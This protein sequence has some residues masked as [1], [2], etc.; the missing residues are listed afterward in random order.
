MQ[1]IA[2]LAER[3]EMT[4]EDA[5]E[6]LRKLQ[7]QVNDPDTEIDDDA[8]DLLLDIDEDETVFEKK[9]AAIKKAE[10]KAREEERKK[11][12]AEAKRKA[13]EAKRKAAAKKKAVPAKKKAATSTKSHTQG[14]ESAQVASEEA[15]EDEESESAEGADV[16]EILSEPEEEVEEAA[17]EGDAEVG[18][19]ETAE[20][21]L[22][23]VEEHAAEVLPD[24]LEATETAPEDIAEVETAAS[25]P[26]APKAPVMPRAEIIVDSEEDARSAAVRLQE[27][28]ELSEEDA[29]HSKGKLAAAEQRHEAE[30]RRRATREKERQQKKQEE[31]QGAVVSTV[32]PDPDVVA[33]VIRRDQER[34]RREQEK[35]ERRK[36]GPPPA[37]KK[38]D[39]LAA[40]MADTFNPVALAPP[41]IKEKGK[42]DASLSK[43]ARKKVKR[44]E[45]TRMREQ[46]SLREAAAAVKEFQAGAVAGGVRKRRKKRREDQVTE[47]S[48]QPIGGIIEVEEMV[49]VEALANLMDVPVSEIILTLMDENISAT[50]NQTLDMEVVRLVAGKLNFE[51]RVVIPEEEALFAKEEDDPASLK[52]RPPVVTVMGHVDHGKTSLLDVIRSTKVAEG[53]AGGITQHIAAYDIE[54]EQGRVTFLDTPGHQAFTQMRARG[55]H[56]TDVVVL[57]VA[58]NDGVKP[59]TI[60]AIDHAT[61]AEVPIVVAI[62]KC[63][64]DNA[65]P[66][67]VRQELTKYGLVDDAWGGKV[68]MRNISAKMNQGVTE[69]MEMLVLQTDMLELRANPDKRARGAI[70]ESEIA[71]GLGPVAWVLVQDGTLRVGDTFLAGSTYGRVRSMTT[72]RGE[73]VQEAGPSMP[74]AVTGFETPPDAGDIFIVTPDERVARNIAEKRAARSKLKRGPATRHMTLEDFHARFEGQEQKKLNVIIKSDVQGSVDVLRTSFAKMGN[75][76]VSIHVIHSGVG[77]INESDVVLADASDAVIIGFHVTANAKV[78]KLAEQVGVDIRTYRI[79]YEALD[80]VRNALEGMLTP[81]KK[82]VVLGHAEVRE[83]FSSSA[84][85]NIAGCYMTDGEAQRNASARLVRD[86]VIV[87]EG[88]VVSLRRQKDDVRS[89][90]TGY[91]CGIK[92]EKFNDIH[93][94]DVI[95]MF[96]IESVAKTL[97]QETS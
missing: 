62:N 70:V 21:P 23:E 96:K 9:Y 97:V 26:A 94:G 25:E 49:S 60:E 78:Q 81:D 93:V 31:K 13:A 12:A 17:V 20:A 63:D 61:A 95:E 5:V 66:D 1:T 65:Q 41:P 29:A 89:V 4:A 85:G 30:E 55:A 80:Q 14:E 84:L 45:R 73:N 37:P 47:T 88:T 15:E 79:I 27:K 91:E 67:R 2:S 28:S 56:I 51:V 7:F 74:V 32:A 54:I 76:E 6:V 68:I 40:P 59:Q 33:E 34:K 53:E 57:V 83:V 35:K 82:E 48:D 72:C 8:V 10:E 11:E 43:T 18:S 46:N 38:S 86:G 69:L 44:A 52:P 71:V 58:A 64:L 75:E 19:A 90:A 50:K 42:T 24:V 39:R 22:A 77:G 3:L 87:H 92:L 36:Q 16:A